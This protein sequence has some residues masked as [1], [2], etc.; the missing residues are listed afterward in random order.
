[1]SELKITLDETKCPC[2]DE[3]NMSPMSMAKANAARNLSGIP[4]I[5]N[6]AAR[7]R[8]KNTEVKGASKSAH[9]SDKEAGEYA[10]AFDVS[11]LDSRTRFKILKAIFTVG[12]TRIGIAKTFIHFDDDPSLDQEVCWLYS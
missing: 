1:M 11:A 5:I 9:V 3:N 6:S 8:A 10:F 12:F 7:C 2:C 4:Y